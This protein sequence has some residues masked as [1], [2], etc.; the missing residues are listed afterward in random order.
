MAIEYYGVNT[1]KALAPSAANVLDPGEWGGRVRVQTDSIESAS[2]HRN[3]EIQFGILPKGATFIG[4]IVNCQAGWGGSVTGTFY[5]DG[6]TAG[7]AITSALDLDTG[8]AGITAGL[9][10]AEV[11]TTVTEETTVSMKVSDHAVTA[12]KYIQV[13]VLYTTD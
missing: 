5:L 8:T 6:A 11:L 1:T 12:D 9:L 13:A 4:L 7:T 3:S 10:G 2:G